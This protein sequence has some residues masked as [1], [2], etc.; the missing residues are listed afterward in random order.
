[1]DK[2]KIAHYYIYFMVYACVGWIY[3]VLLGILQFHLGF[4][5]RGFLYGPYLPVYGF[6]ALLLILILDDLRS[7]KHYLLQVNIT[8]FL[9]FMAIV[10][11]TTVVEL[12]TSYLL[13]F[14]IG[15]WLWDYND[16]FMN[17][18]GRIALETSL[19]FGFGGMVI[20]YIIHP[21]LKKL[22]KQYERYTVFLAVLIG[23][24]FLMDVL[25]RLFLGSNI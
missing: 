24:P 23:I 8:P 1:M 17:F 25:M 7:I 5:N 12:G 20:L 19:R 3:E 16:Y 2:K 10:T 6:G 15:R 4:I 13:E 9:I 18:Q 14:I 22:T 21:I 11:I